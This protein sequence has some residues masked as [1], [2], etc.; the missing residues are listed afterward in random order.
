MK[1]AK[2]DISRFQHKILKFYKEHERTFPWR[3]TTDPYKILVSEIMLQQTQTSRVSEKY[4]IFLK[5]FPTVSRLAQTKQSRVLKLWQG[6]GYNRRALYL[7]QTA[8]IIR[9]NYN[10]KV[11]SLKKDL[12]TLPGIGINTAGAVMAFA[13]NIPAVFV[14]TNIRRTFIHEFFREKVSVADHEL[15]PFIEASIDINNPRQWYYALMDYGANLGK[16]VPNPNRKSRQYRKQSPLSGSL[17]QTR[18]A[19]LKLLIEKSYNISV[20]REFF[21]DDMKFHE[22]L[23]QLIQEG[24]IT[25]KGDFIDINP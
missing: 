19:L 9:E 11:P 24:F 7:Y 2:K 6:L 16:N 22:A 10:G 20:L 13:F 5:A 18:G 1:F 25:K 8:K 12:V 4:E 3:D 15:Y 14:E 21:D 23:D 17:R